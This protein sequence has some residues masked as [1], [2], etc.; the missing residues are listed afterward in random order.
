MGVGPARRVS[1]GGPRIVVVT[2]GASG[3][4]EAIAHRFAVDGD[5]VVVAD[6]DESRSRQVADNLTAAGLAAESATV[7]VTS[8]GEVAAMLD[9]VA[10]RH[11]RLDALVCTAAIDVNRRGSS[12][13]CKYALPLIAKSGGGATVVIG[14][15]NAELANLAVHARAN[16]GPVAYASTSS[17]PRR[18]TPA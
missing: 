16:T 6:A 1:L 3:L 11:G 17:L 8:E 18:T 5:R 12:L 15:A 9:A 2:G 13:C 7:D 14:E 10:E 4:G